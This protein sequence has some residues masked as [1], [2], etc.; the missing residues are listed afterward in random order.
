MK[1][2]V[3]G[4][5]GREHAITWKLAQSPR[6]KRLWAAPGNAGIAEVAEC[7]DIAATDID[8]LLQFAEQN[9]VDIT[10]VGPE[11]PLIAGVVDAFEAKG[12]AIF[13]PS[14][15]PAQLEGSKAF[16]KETMRRYNVPTATAQ[17]FS[18][19]GPACEYVRQAYDRG[20][21]SLVVKADGEAA[22]KGVF[23]THSVDEAV[24]AV[25]GL[26]DEGLLGPAGRTV[27][28]EE[29]LY[30][31]EASLLAL[32]DGKNAL[33][34][35]PVQDNKRALDGDRGLNTGGMGC[36]APVPFITP[37]R[38][39][40]AL[41]TIIYPTI[42]ATRD[43]G[44]PFRGVLYAGI[45]M[46]DTGMK[47]LE[48]NVRFG[49]PE[50]QV[51][52]PLMDTDLLDVIEGVVQCRLDRVHV[53]WRQQAAVTV[54]VASG[55]Y[56]G[57]YQRGLPISGLREA[58]AVPGVVVFHAGTA[59][60]DGQVVTSGGRVLCVTALGDTMTQARASAYEAIRCIQFE[61][62]HFRTDIGLKWC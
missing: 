26:L 16:A 23:I 33:L 14:K 25:C 44:I 47:T 3:V 40:E 30:G 38:Q 22:G 34:M 28:V 45:M 21:K 61:C 18:T 60:A 39:Q 11:S 6:V 53:T 36:T 58:A 43:R 7:V 57:K 17:A 12:L 49:D 55:G 9:R 62:M 5:G 52:L 37:E 29:R 1:I 2:L 10:V 20:A 51:L 54:V 32:T 15:D 35:P 31:E 48:F 59:L 41:D 50:T 42:Q 8:G 27:V 19:S 46:T 13:G 24:E 56:P 4:G